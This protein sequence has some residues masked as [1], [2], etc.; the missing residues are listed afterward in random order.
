MH[1]GVVYPQVEM[2]GDPGLV[3]D[4]TETAEGLG[5]DS[6]LAYEHVLGA[7]PDHH[8]L[9]GPY[10]HLDP[11]HEPFVLF[12]YMAAI[13]TKIEMWLGV[14]VL[15]QRQTAL[16]AKQVASL[17][18]LSGGRFTL[19]VGVGWNQVEYHALGQDFSTRGRRFEEQ[20]ALLRRLW[21]ED[22]VTFEGEF[23]NVVRAGIKPRPER[24]V[25][26]WIGG[27]ADPV[28]R[29]IG[30]WAD[31]WLASAGSPKTANLPDRTGNPVG[32]ANRMKLVEAAAR[33]KGRDPSE[34]GVGMLIG[35]V[36]FEGLVS[37]DAAEYAHRARVWE[38]AGVTH[39]FLGTIGNEF[40]P[41]QQIAAMTDFMEAYRNGG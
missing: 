35:D 19:G 9:I 25:P 18:I 13:T 10:T 29:R 39:G 15:P 12:G 1:I 8:T 31:G 16:V 11:F 41:D 6:I 21:E 33:E 27:W 28:L 38:Q 2:P 30:Y 36:G 34:I 23:D 32:L 37:W 14:L 40:T 24:R 20:I 22:L 7:D 5:F 3:R 17:D 26:L 4:W